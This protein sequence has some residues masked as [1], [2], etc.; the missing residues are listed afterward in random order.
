MPIDFNYHIVFFV[1]F[2]IGKITGKL[3]GIFVINMLSF[4]GVKIKFEMT[5]IPVIPGVKHK[6]SD[7]NLCMAASIHALE[8][9]I[10]HF[11][12]TSC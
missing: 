6:I 3:P 12:V 5:V 9:N 7:L 4:A 11:F 1:L 10:F 8:V 2:S